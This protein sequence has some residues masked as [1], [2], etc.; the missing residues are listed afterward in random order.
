LEFATHCK[1]V[2]N[3]VETGGV[4]KDLMSRPVTRKVTVG[5][6]WVVENKDGLTLAEVLPVISRPFHS[7]LAY[8]RGNLRRLHTQGFY[9]DWR[10]I[11]DTKATYPTPKDWDDHVKAFGEIVEMWENTVDEVDAIM[12]SV[13]H[14]QPIVK[15]NR[16]GMVV[17]LLDDEA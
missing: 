17:D 7:H 6:R 13:S 15:E 16:E 10:A 11:R 9:R 5:G 4:A 1:R 8:W 3:A 2:Y 14:W 12:S